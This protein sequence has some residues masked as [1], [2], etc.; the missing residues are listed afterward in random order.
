MVAVVPPAVLGGVALVVLWFGSGRLSA[1]IG[2]LAG[3][4]AAPGLLAVGAPIAEQS[5]YP[6]AIAASVLFWAVIGLTA[7]WRATR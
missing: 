3:V 2:L 4:T 5:A 6:I 7:A 1:L